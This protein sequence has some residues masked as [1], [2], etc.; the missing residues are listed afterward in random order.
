MTDIPK[1]NQLNMSSS[2]GG[3]WVGDWEGYRRCAQ[4]EREGDGCYIKE[5]DEG[6]KGKLYN[7]R[8]RLRV[9]FLANSRF[10]LR[11]SQNRK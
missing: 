4:E 7:N 8:E 10:K 11:I 2:G 1:K 9:M 6:E 3:Q 5:W